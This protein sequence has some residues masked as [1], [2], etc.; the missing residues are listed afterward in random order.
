[1]WRGTVSLLLLLFLHQRVDCF[2]QGRVTCRGRNRSGRGSCLRMDDEL[3]REGIKQELTTREDEYLSTRFVRLSSSGH[4]LTP[5]SLEERS[6]VKKSLQKEEEEKEEEKEGSFMGEGKKG[7]Y[8]SRI[9]G[10][11]LYTSGHRIDRLCS[12]S[13][14]YFEMPCDE[15]H[16]LITSNSMIR[17]VRSQEI[18]GQ[19]VLYNTEE[20]EDK[21][22][23]QE[24][25]E[26]EEGEEDEGEE[27]GRRLVHC[28]HASSLR[29][30]PLHSAWPVESQPENFWGTEGQYR[31]WNQ[32]EM[33]N[34]PLSY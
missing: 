29:F 2:S 4:D 30:L 28:I 8:V 24:E 14:L 5:L 20:D 7:M 11:P 1:M 26:G 16:I 27:G 23:G 13:N 18:V 34:R 32:H 21:E 22:K 17:C 15:D 33:S 10:L 3:A 19:L 31:S 12:A 6:E 25:E 9:G